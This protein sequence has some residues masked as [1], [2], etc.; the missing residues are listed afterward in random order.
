MGHGIDSDFFSPDASVARGKWILSVGRLMQSKRHDLAI[1]FAMQEE[2][3][4]RIAGEGPER[5]HLEALASE[6]GARVRFLGGVSQSQL[7]DEYRKAERLIHTSETGSLDKVVLEALACGLPVRTNDQAL[8]ALENA[9]PAYVREHHS[10]QR[11]IPAIL[12]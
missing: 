6:L 11:L 5:M 2:K 3:E 9:N 10:L 8:K 12:D 7:R 1:R 4:L